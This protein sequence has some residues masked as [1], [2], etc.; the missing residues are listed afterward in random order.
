MDTKSNALMY[1]ELAS[2]LVI[3]VVRRVWPGCVLT[4]SLTGGK[5]QGNIL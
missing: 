2:V 1:R 5:T 3:T 4:E